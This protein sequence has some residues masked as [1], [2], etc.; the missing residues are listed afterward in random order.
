ME[1]ILVKKGIGEFFSKMYETCKGKNVFVELR[2][3]DNK[4]VIYYKDKGTF[5]YIYLADEHLSVDELIKTLSK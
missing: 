4:I 1:K 2:P 3:D 5:D